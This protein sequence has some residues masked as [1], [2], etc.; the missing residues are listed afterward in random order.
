MEAHPHTAAQVL[1]NIE[2]LVGSQ[3]SGRARESQPL[4]SGG[5]EAG[6]AAH[7]PHPNLED[8]DPPSEAMGDERDAQA[9]SQQVTP[10]SK[11][12]LRSPTMQ[13]LGSQVSMPS[14]VGGEADDD[15]VIAGHVWNISNVSGRR[16]MHFLAA[17][18]PTSLNMVF[19][20]GLRRSK[21][22]RNQY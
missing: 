8:K 11:G 3:M 13:S 21:E 2:Q 19:L 22:S 20:K 18:E 4:Q 9:E 14:E 5:P 7:N 1:G 16:L 17:L 15:D 10:S 12:I 6:F